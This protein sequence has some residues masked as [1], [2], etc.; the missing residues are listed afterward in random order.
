MR[1]AV[2]YSYRDAFENGNRFGR[3]YTDIERELPSE[4]EIEKIENEIR[5]AYVKPHVRDVSIVNIIPLRE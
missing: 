1:V 4:A 3:C 2:I 5:K